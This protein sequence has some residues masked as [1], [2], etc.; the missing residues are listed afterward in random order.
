[1]QNSNCEMQNENLR[2]K[3]FNYFISEKE[4]IAEINQK[5]YSFG[6]SA[7]SPRSFRFKRTRKTNSRA[8]SKIFQKGR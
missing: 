5:I 2:S 4:K 8:L 1:M 7:D 3:I 6:K